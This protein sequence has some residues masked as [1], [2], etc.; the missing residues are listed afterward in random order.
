[1]RSA[2]VA[3]KEARTPPLPSPKTGRDAGGRSSL[4]AAADSYKR[5]LSS[6]GVLCMALAGNIVDQAQAPSVAAPAAKLVS[7]PANPAPEGVATGMLRTPDKVS[8]RYARWEPPQRPQGHRRHLSGPHRVHREILRGGARPARPRLCGRGTRLARPGAVAAPAAR[9]PQ[10]PH[11]Q[12][13]PSTT[14]T[15]RRSCRR[16][17]CPIVRRPS[18]R[19]ATRWAPPCCCGRRSW[20][21]AGS[22]AWCCARR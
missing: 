17:S 13:R 8:I 6:L 10:G 21:T 18:M 11:P 5:G 9:Q 12:L 16:S 2:S 19:S 14:S 22:T 4:S 15:W 1:M 7:I 3:S 20:G